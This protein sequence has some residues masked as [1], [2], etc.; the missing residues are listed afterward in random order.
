MDTHKPVNACQQSENYAC[1]DICD[2]NLMMFLLNWWQL[3][4]WDAIST[5]GLY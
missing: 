3:S 4:P 2:Y 1:I 5:L